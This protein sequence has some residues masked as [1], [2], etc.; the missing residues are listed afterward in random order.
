MQKMV[1]YFWRYAS[2]LG[3]PASG[4][5][6]QQLLRKHLKIKMHGYYKCVNTPGLWQHATKPI[7][8]S[9][10]INNFGIKYVGKEHADH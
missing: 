5:I 4:Y 6:S 8:F 2:G 10:V 9:L 7:T 1:L 3:T